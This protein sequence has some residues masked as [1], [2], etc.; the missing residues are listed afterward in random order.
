MRQL[1]S[2]DLIGVTG[3][4]KAVGGQ[5]VHAFVLTVPRM[6]VPNFAARVSSCLSA[7]RITATERS[8]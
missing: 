4:D 6:H 8:V 1:G 2:S 3:G 7:L 5:G